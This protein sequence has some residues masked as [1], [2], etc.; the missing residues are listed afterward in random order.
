MRK[1]LEKLIGEI[2]EVKWVDSGLGDRSKIRTK[3]SALE[4]NTTYGILTNVFQDSRLHTIMCKS[5]CQCKCLELAMDSSGEEDDHS[6]N[7]WIWC[8]AVVSLR[9]LK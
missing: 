1:D 9:V 6:D 5:V 7:A 4:I 2:I 3:T 8:K